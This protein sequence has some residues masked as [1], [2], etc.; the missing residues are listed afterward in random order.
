LSSLDLKHEGSLLGFWG[1]EIR[2]GNAA[3]EML[4]AA[5]E[6]VVHSRSGTRRYFDLAERAL[7]ADVLAAPDPHETDEDYQNWHVL[8]RVGGLGLANPGAAE[9][10]L[11]IFGLNGDARRAA[12]ARLAERGDLLS[13][14][15]EG[16]NSR[17]LF[18]RAADLATLE[19]VQND[20]L[21]EPR[22]AIIGAL[23]NL[24]WDRNLLRWVF[25]FDYVWEVYKPLA[26]RTYGYYV[27]PVLY[28]DRF[29]AR[30]QP[31]FDR[32]T[33]TMTIANWW[34]EEGVQPDGAMESALAAC[35]R[36]FARYLPAASVALGERIAGERSLQWVS[37]AHL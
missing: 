21:P 17:P 5:G 27:L 15:V 2:I 13:V 11:G 32:K 29:V 12:L 22:A 1:R 9:Y 33:R 35:F 23:D 26:Q 6:L 7:P 4:Y 24:M 30:F 37:S 3:L 28:G 16:A 18:M 8:R 20:P 10:W 36:E 31:E 25:D 19:A 34:W 14:A